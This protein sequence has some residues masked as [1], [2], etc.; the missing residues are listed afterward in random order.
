MKFYVP[1]EDSP[2]LLLNLISMP[3][4]AG[5]PSPAADYIESRIDLNKALIKNPA[6][7]FLASADGDSMFP[8]IKDGDLLII[9]RKDE[10]VNGWKVLTSVN[11]EFCVKLFFK[12]PDGSIELRPANPMFPS[13]HLPSE[14]EGDFDYFGRVIC[15]IDIFDK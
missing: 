4:S 7:T 14:F 2:E 9:D 5:F 12:Y 1:A 6:T 3:L 11:N 10:P 15:S 13:I 8:D